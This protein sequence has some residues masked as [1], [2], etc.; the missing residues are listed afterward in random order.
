MKFSQEDPTDA[1]LVHSYDEQAIVIQAGSKAELTTL[2]N[3]FLLTADTLVQPPSL[4]SLK[5]WDAAMVDYLRSHDLEIIITGQAVLQRVSAKEAVLL[6]QYGLGLEQ[7]LI[8]PA[9]RTYNLLVTEG[10]KVG[11]IID[12][13][14]Q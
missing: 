8:G 10:R 9:C 3:A 2:T 7:M 4:P 5:C 14:Y 13:N 6:A 1:Q 12:F 11:L